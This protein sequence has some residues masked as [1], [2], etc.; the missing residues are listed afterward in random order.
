M[1]FGCNYCAIG[2]ANGCD[3]FEFS[4]TPSAV[5]FPQSP[6]FAN[7]TA[8]RNCFNMGDRSDDLDVHSLVSIGRLDYLNCSMVGGI[9]QLV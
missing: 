3:T 9:S 8:N 2:E 4:P 1:H 5:H 6:G 7:R